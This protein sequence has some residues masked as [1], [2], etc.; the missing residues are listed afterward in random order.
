M[1]VIT[2][3]VQQI[4]NDLIES[5]HEDGTVTIDD[6]LA[7]MESWVREDFGCGWGHTYDTCDLIYQTPDGEDLS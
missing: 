6:V 7:Y 5:G 1:K 4:V 2:Y 3:D